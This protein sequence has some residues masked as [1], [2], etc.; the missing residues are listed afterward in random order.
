MNY[1]K[2]SNI[3]LR[4][5]IHLM[6][7]IA[8]LVFLITIVLGAIRSLNIIQFSTIGIILFH[9]QTG[10]LGWATLAIIA[11][12]F[13]IFFSENIENNAFLYKLILFMKFSIMIILLLVFSFYVN[14]IYQFSFIIPIFS[15]GVFIVIFTTLVLCL[16][17]I[18]RIPFFTSYHLLIVLGLG[19]CLYG[20]VFGSIL[21]YQLM[22]GTSIFVGDNSGLYTTYIETSY[23]IVMITGIIEW[24]F[25]VDSKNSI[26]TIV[27][28]QGFSLLLFPIFFSF[29]LLLNSQIL[30][31][32]AL[33]LEIIGFGVFS[34]R[35][36]PKLLKVDI[37]A[38][39]TDRYLVIASIFFAINVILFVLLIS[40]I[41]NGASLSSLDILN[42]LLTVNHTIVLGITTNILFAIIIVNIFDKD[43]LIQIVENILVIGFNGC[44]WLFL[45]A[46]LIESS[47]TIAAYMGIFLLTMV[48]IL[49][50]KIGITHYS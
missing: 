39:K 50:Y 7:A 34:I 22:N 3:D 29:G 21:S 49:L 47:L 40:K 11:T 4:N 43:G 1:Q 17:Q 27:I 23:L 31:L 30:I 36:G 25:E 20:I 35:I 14:T 42:L 8:L 24:Q 15:F 44:L 28:I 10:I 26:N 48:V 38:G 9:L 13:W 2:I 45:I 6:Y 46:I 33:L 19:L 18:K 12:S 32:L 37:I 5:T 16:N 41:I